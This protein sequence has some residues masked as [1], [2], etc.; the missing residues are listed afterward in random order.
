MK[1]DEKKMKLHIMK[2]INLVLPV[3]RKIDVK[4]RYELN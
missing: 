2:K 1:K 4:F 3:F